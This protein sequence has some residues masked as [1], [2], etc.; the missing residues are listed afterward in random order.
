M[1]MCAIKTIKMN[2][3]TMSHTTHNESIIRMQKCLFHGVKVKEMFTF[4]LVH[5][6][7]YT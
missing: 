5:V 7:P 2:L 6:P 3:K 4:K 1:V